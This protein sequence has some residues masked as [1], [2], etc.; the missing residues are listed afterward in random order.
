MALSGS[1][2]DELVRCCTKHG[3]DVAL[4]RLQPPRWRYVRICPYSSEW[5][6]QAPRLAAQDQLVAAMACTEVEPTPVATKR[7]REGIA[8]AQI[9]SKRTVLSGRARAPSYGIATIASGSR[10]LPK[11]VTW[12]PG[13]ISI[14]ASQQV[15]GCRLER[16]GA[17]A[18]MDAASAAACYALDPQ[19]GERVL[20]LC[21]APGSKLCLLADLMHRRGSLVGVDISKDRLHVARALASRQQLLRGGWWQPGFRLALIQAD[22]TT[23]ALDAADV[24]CLASEPL[25]Q[26][27]GR[28]DCLTGMRARLEA[29]LRSLS[30]SRT[31]QAPPP[32]ELSRSPE[33]V[34]AEAT[35]VSSS[36][37]NPAAEGE[38]ESSTST[39]STSAAVDAAAAASLSVRLKAK[40]SVTADSAIEALATPRAL[41]GL[42][43]PLP[44]PLAERCIQ[45]ELDSMTTAAS[46]P[47]AA[48]IPSGCAAPPEGSWDRVLVDAPCTHDGSVRHLQKHYGKGGWAAVV[49]RLGLTDD[50]IVAAAELQLAILRRAF[51]LLR[52]GGCL[53]YSTCSTSTTQN[54]GVLERFMKAYGDRAALMPIPAANGATCSGER[55]D[56]WPTKPGGLPHTL[57]FDPIKGVTSGLFLAKLFKVY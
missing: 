14:P 41:K 32:H 34:A 2:P 37:A 31:P 22:A 40:L 30:T 54:E 28:Y 20:D 55:M 50:G 24:P 18:G 26:G 47:A 25:P 19:P 8:P 7:A 12:L 57:R 45:V 43:A 56:A 46:A 52:R 11:R 21:A 36:P 9:G 16:I 15:H 23:F 13:M 6:G 4:L 27:R 53:V 1:P 49:A 3:V 42:S 38:A 44:A 5:M 33:A 17:A 29:A 51:A 10:P 48:A 39:P 35:A